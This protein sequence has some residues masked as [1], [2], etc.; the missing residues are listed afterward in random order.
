MMIEWFTPE[1][2]SNIDDISS[3]SEALAKC[4][5]TF[6]SEETVCSV[7]SALEVELATTVGPTQTRQ[8]GHPF[9]PIITFQ[10]QPSLIYTK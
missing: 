5:S 8:N 6:S 10:P 3:V 7:S 4:S 1:L 9:T 2:G